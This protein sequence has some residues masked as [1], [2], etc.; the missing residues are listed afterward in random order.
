MFDKL[1]KKFNA[2]IDNINGT[3]EVNGKK[4]SGNNV[5]ISKGKVIIDGVVQDEI[6]N[7]PVN[8][9]I[10]GSCGSIK[11]D[12]GDIRCGDVNGNV[13]NSVGDVSCKNV[14]GNVSNST[15]DIS[16]SKIEGNAT[17]SVGD[18]G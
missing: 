12:V 13:T 14:K 7:Q 10:T 5:Y 17:T 3:I 15:G 4:Y 9:T 2:M 6:V 16:C 11:N 1:M 8:I 18:I